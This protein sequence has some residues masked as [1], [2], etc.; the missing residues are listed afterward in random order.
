[1]LP[2]PSSSH[3][4]SFLVINNKIQ[5]V[6]RK[7]NRPMAFQRTSGHHQKDLVPISRCTMPPHCWNNGRAVV[8]NSTPA[9]SKLCSF[10]PQRS[11]SESLWRS[12]GTR[13]HSC[14]FW[15]AVWNGNLTV[16]VIHAL[17][18]FKSLCF[19]FQDISS[20]LQPAVTVGLVH[21]V[22]ARCLPVNL[23]KAKSMIYLIYLT[24]PLKVSACYD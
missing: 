10:R 6:W 24:A 23:S 22:R 13:N 15:Y 8:G 5:P 20:V 2:E 7:P 21:R 4:S 3:A 9:E 16:S 14:V 12:L 11:R 18:Q 17:L 1:M 19:S